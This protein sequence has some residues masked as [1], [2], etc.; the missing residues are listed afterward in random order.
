MWEFALDQSSVPKE[1]RLMNK[2]HIKRAVF[3]GLNGGSLASIEKIARHIMPRNK[4][5]SRPTNQEDIR[6]AK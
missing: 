3:N 2:G 4:K 6:I 1:R 5:N